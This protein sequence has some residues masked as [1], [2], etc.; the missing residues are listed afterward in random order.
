M[1]DEITDEQRKQFLLIREGRIQGLGHV[2][3]LL[4]E[5]I[6]RLPPEH[7][8]GFYY[9]GQ[10]DA[11]LAFRTLIRSI[12]D[13]MQLHV[14]PERLWPDWLSAEYRAIKE[15]VIAAMDRAEDNSEDSSGL[16]RTHDGERSV[17][18]SSI[19]EALKR[20]GWLPPEQFP[21]GAEKP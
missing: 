17:Y 21:T 20:A 7:E 15:M 10:H 13:K 5:A 16:S 8:R 3:C 1:T 18:A 14:T 6:E 11:L 4:D 9:D 12:K 2:E 19:A